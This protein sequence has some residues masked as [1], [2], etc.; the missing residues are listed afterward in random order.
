MKYCTHCG[1]QLLD[2]A[3]ICLS[4]GCSPPQDTIKNAQKLLNILSQRLHTNGII[5]A[6]IGTLQILSGLFI[7]WFIVV[8]GVLNIIAASNDIDYSKKMCIH[9]AGIVAKFQPILRPIII[10]IYN[11]FFGGIIGV[12][13]TL[14]YFIAIREYVM[15]N[16]EIFSVFDTM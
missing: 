5:W 15:E 7:N 3:I 8:V 6:A 11:L 2:E 10:L 14:Y 13:G 16:K 12:A 1:K 4:C 9:P